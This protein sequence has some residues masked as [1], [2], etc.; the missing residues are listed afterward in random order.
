MAQIEIADF[1]FTDRAIAKIWYHGIDTDQLYAVL[2][3]S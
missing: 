3:D 1:D 2:D